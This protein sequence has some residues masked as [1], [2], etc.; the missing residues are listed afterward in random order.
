MHQSN[1]TAEEMAAWKEEFI[2]KSSIKD[3]DIQYFRELTYEG[4]QEQWEEAKPVS[5]YVTRRKKK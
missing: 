1:P 4:L 5:H 3:E 2:Q